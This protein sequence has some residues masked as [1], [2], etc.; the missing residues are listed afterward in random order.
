M[1]TG[2]KTFP[3]N[4]VSPWRGWGYDLGWGKDVSLRMEEEM[5][6]GREDV[7]WEN[8]GFG[9]RWGWGED[10]ETNGSYPL[11]WM[12]AKNPNICNRSID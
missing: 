2:E 5:G 4:K 6:L 8:V 10:V 3:R 1:W 12:H 9:N 11:E 7:P